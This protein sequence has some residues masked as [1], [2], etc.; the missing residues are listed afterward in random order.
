MQSCAQIRVMVVTDQ[1]IM[2][3]GLRLRIERERDLW[4]VCEASD[5][6]QATRDLIGCRPDLVV[7]DLQLPSGEDLRAIKALDSLSPETPMVVLADYPIDFAARLFR[8][9]APLVTVSKIV[10]GYEVISA[11]REA[12]VRAQGH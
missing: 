4:V 9:K 8:R 3:D 7:I 5:L 12:I 1:P 11:I 2:R 6:I 10:T